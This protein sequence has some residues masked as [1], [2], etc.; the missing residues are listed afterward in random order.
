MHW[1]SKCILLVRHKQCEWLS[2]RSKQCICFNVNTPKTEHKVN[3]Y[4]FI[5]CCYNS[6][7]NTTKIKTV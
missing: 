7:H 5:I 2:L 1:W 3:V 6:L 4:S